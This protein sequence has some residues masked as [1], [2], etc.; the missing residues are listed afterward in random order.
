MLTF[1]DQMKNDILTSVTSRQKPVSLRNRDIGSQLAFFCSPSFSAHNWLLL[2][3]KIIVSSY[4]Q[5][6]LVLVTNKDIESHCSF[7]SIFVPN[8]YQMMYCQVPI[9]CTRL[10]NV[11]IYIFQINQYVQL[12]MDGNFPNSTYNRKSSIVVKK[13]VR[14]I[15]F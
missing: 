4:I 13:T 1:K 10:I 14:W 9:I 6:K 15:F 5:K 11:S 3:K 7:L 8:Q 12:E 2:S